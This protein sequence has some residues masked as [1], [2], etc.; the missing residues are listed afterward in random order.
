MDQP[1]I[2]DQPMAPQGRDTEHK[3]HSETDDIE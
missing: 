2:T 3:Q 1:Q